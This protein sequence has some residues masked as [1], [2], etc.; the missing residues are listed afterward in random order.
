MKD[1]HQMQLPLF[2]ASILNKIAEGDESAFKILYDKYKSKVYTL[3][4][5]IIKH[6]ELSEEIL[7]DVFTGIWIKKEN[8]LTID[9][10]DAYLFVITK[11]KS[12]SVL[13]KSKKESEYQESYIT[14]SDLNS[15]DNNAAEYVMFK[16]TQQLIFDIL[17]TLPPQKQKIWTL[18]KL[19]G[20]SRKEIA[21]ELNLSENTVRNHLLAAS[22]LI[23]LQLD[24]KNILLISILLWTSTY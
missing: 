17:K 20:Y 7:M 12:L 1:Q 5:S 13:K 18:N 6:K 24:D 16:E 4:F 23:K 11:N 15:V 3:A 2:S 14:N 9:N 10:F 19:E 8:L 21:L 22:N